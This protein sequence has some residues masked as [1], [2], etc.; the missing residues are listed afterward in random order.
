MASVFPVSSQMIAISA[1]T[2]VAYMQLNPNEGI[3]VFV[4]ANTAR[5]SATLTLALFDAIRS[6]DGNCQGLSEKRSSAA[7]VGWRV[8]G[9]EIPRRKFARAIH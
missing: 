2:S 3:R 1:T 5:L 4:M 8:F 7:D 6:A 9:E